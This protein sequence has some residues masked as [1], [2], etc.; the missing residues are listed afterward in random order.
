MSPEQLETWENVTLNYQVEINP[1]KAAYVDGG[2]IFT[3]TNDI[4]NIKTFLDMVVDGIHVQDDQLNYLEDN[5]LRYKCKKQSVFN[6]VSNF[7]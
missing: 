5:Y 6:H 3:N 7:S 1:L 4:T 2:E